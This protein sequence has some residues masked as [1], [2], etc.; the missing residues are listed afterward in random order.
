M[1]GIPNTRLVRQLAVGR[2]SYFVLDR[3]QKYG[4][5]LRHGDNTTADLYLGVTDYVRRGKSKTGFLAP[6]KKLNA[7]N[8]KPIHTDRKLKV[9]ARQLNLLR[10]KVFA[11]VLRK[12][13]TR[14]IFE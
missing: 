10:T 8:A 5:K 7:V 14:R 4:F 6:V 9:Q 13:I 12:K 3:T 1:G 2:F 11:I